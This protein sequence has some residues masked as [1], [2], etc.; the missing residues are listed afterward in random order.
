[1]G[2][3]RTGPAISAID[4]PGIKCHQLKSSTIHLKFF[5]KMRINYFVLCKALTAF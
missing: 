3:G 4:S 5:G 2:A 1:M